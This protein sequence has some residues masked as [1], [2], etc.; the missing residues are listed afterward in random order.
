MHRE[1]EIQHTLKTII[2]DYSQGPVEDLRE[3]KH[4]S[5]AENDRYAPG[6][7]GV[8]EGQGDQPGSS[9]NDAKRCPLPS[10]ENDKV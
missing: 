6:P 7:Q 4:Q 5:I 3:R 10:I 1:F 2:K 9:Q 8:K